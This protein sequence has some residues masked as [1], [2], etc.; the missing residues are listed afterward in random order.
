MF[1][2]LV[3]CKDDVH[4]AGETESPILE[5]LMQT[6]TSLPSREYPP[7]W[8]TPGKHH[9]VHHLSHMQAVKP[10][11]RIFMFR[12]G[13]GIIGVGQAT[14]RIQ[15]PILPEDKHRIRG[16]GWAAAEWRVPVSWIRWQPHNP[17]D[18]FRS[19]WAF[20]K[21]TDRPHLAAVLNHFGL[22]Q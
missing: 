4:V 7:N 1:D 5:D 2:E 20:Y 22:N 14:G 19:P 8:P 12:A 15:G 16:T 13:R 11:D 9:T 18:G 3:L 17:C 21:V 10:E 6:R